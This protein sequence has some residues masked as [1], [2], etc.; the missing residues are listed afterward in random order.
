MNTPLFPVLQIPE[1]YCNDYEEVR[2]PRTR[3]NALLRALIDRAILC[4]DLPASTPDFL[5]SDSGCLR[6]LPEVVP[7]LASQAFDDLDQW[8][9]ILGGPI[10]A[11]VVAHGGDVG[12]LLAP[13]FMANEILQVIDPYLAPG[14]C[15]CRNA[16]CS[17]GSTNRLDK[18]SSAKALL[19][20]VARPERSNIE[21]LRVATATRKYH[22]FPLQADAEAI[23][24]WLLDYAST[25]VPPS[26]T[27]SEMTWHLFPRQPARVHDRFLGFWAQGRKGRPPGG[28]DPPWHALSIGYGVRALRNDSEGHTCVARISQT[29][30][31]DVLERA[32]RHFT[33]EVFLSRQV[34]SSD[35]PEWREL[36]A[37][38]Q[39]SGEWTLCIRQRVQAE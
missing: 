17:C 31:T 23:G 27:L 16:T 2:F 14:D 18:D 36:P 19:S 21:I 34:I 1:D 32:R 24:R 37:C 15:R 4:T 38:R 28:G 35:P 10:A 11:S 33:W 22:E 3:Q 30:F 13:C 7:P 39:S 12:S 5:R 20:L 6:V 29:Q 25:N 9:Q 8:E 26:S